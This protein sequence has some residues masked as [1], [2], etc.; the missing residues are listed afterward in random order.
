MPSLIGPVSWSMEQRARR[1]CR[2]REN[3]ERPWSSNETIRSERGDDGGPRGTKAARLKDAHFIGVARS[4]RPLKYLAA[5]FVS[6]APAELT[7]PR[8][9]DKKFRKRKKRE[10]RKPSPDFFDFC[11]SRNFLQILSRRKSYTRS[12]IRGY[13][14]SNHANQ[15]IAVPTKVTIRSVACTTCTYPLRHISSKVGFFHNGTGSHKSKDK[16]KDKYQREELNS[17]FA[18]S[19]PLGSKFYG[20][21][22]PPHPCK[23][24]LRVPLVHRYL[25]GREEEEEERE[26]ERKS[27]SSGRLFLPFDD[28]SF[29]ASFQPA[30]RGTL[31]IGNR[32]GPRGDVRVG[33]DP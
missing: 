25:N 3:R 22:I 4:N 33:D 30:L 31:R 29:F 24:L 5:L 23:I 32:V 13:F 26:K 6:M 28:S 10:I 18:Q 19:L 11:Y 21:W 15:G 20:D 14:R 27:Y 12:Y 9:C 2:N 17:N 8:Q 7:G 16:E 1:R